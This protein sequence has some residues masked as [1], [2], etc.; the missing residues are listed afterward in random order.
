MELD[1]KFFPFDQKLRII[2]PPEAKPL[3]RRHFFFDKA[4]I[5]YEREAT[6]IQVTAF[7]SALG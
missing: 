1:R 7:A 2:R 5:P 6:Q 3:H 4:L